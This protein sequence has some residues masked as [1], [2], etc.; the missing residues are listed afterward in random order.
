MGLEAVCR[1]KT[2]AGAGEAT[3][4][5]E[6]DAVIVRGTVRTTIPFSAITG[7]EVRGKRLVLLHGGEESLLDLG[8]LAARWAEK[9]RNPKS[10]LEKLGVKPGMLISAVGL[11]DPTIQSEL[12]ASHCTLVWGR[13]KAGSN[14]VLLGVESDA[15][16]KRLDAAARALEEDGALWVVHPKG[17]AGVKDTAVFAAGKALGLVANKVA[18]FS[19]THTAERLVIPVARRTHR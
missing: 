16:L 19:E 13:L 11:S 10:R 1:V 12:A 6:T 15:G 4:L 8:P 7:V 2:P 14:I 3:V 9:I 18:K 17:K 5:L